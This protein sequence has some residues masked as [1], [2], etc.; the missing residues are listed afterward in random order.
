MHGTGGNILYRNHCLNCISDI[1]LS[2][3]GGNTLVTDVSVHMERPTVVSLETYRA[4]QEAVLREREPE[5]LGKNSAVLIA[6]ITA[7]RIF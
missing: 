7:P 1:Y 5:T 3:L 2:G 6:V 4:F